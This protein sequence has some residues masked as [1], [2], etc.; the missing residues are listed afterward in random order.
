MCLVLGDKNRRSLGAVL[1]L[2]AVFPLA[3]IF[4]YGFVTRRRSRVDERARLVDDEKI[5]I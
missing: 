4:K 1:P 2:D 3:R 5:K